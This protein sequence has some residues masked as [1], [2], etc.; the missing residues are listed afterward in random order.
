MHREYY[1]LNAG[2]TIPRNA[3]IPAPI[4]NLWLAESGKSQP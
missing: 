1:V 3:S 2:R 4:L